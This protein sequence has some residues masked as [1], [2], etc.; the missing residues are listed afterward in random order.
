LGGETPVGWNHQVLVGLNPYFL[1][2]LFFNAT[3]TISFCKEARDLIASL[4]ATPP[5]KKK[6]KVKKTWNLIFDSIHSHYHHHQVT[7]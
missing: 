5:P 1:S 2:I 6:K 4:F 3:M 7:H